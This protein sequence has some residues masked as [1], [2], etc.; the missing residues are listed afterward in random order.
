MRLENNYGVNARIDQFDDPNF[1]L[2][3]ENGKLSEYSE[4]YLKKSDAKEIVKSK[5]NP[6]IKSQ[7]KTFEELKEMYPALFDYSAKDLN[8]DKAK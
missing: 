8:E 7:E 4:E 5:L 2:Y 1:G 3:T 6:V